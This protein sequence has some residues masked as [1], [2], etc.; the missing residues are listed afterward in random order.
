MVERRVT[1]IGY[2]HNNV[3]DLSVNNQSARDVLLSITA[4]NL[5]SAILPEIMSDENTKSFLVKSGFMDLIQIFEDKCI[6]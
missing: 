6:P 2:S 1:V 3:I 4:R 5:S